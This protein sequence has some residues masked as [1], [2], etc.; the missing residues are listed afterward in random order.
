[1]F[2]MRRKYIE[3]LYKELPVL[4]KE[5]VLTED[6]AGR[7][8]EYYGEIKKDSGLTIALI[9]FS[10]IGSLLIGSG[11]ILLLAHNWQ[12]LPRSSRAMPKSS[13]FT[14]PSSV[15]RMFEGFRSRCTTSCRCADC[16]ASQTVR[17]SRMRCA[18]EHP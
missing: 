1:M 14:V 15:T 8:R 10:I 5:G 18:T 16:T 13:N 9:I 2:W 17:I 6:N 3:W 7:V 4:V 11:I 12:E